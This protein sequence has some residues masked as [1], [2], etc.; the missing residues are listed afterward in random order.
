MRLVEKERR[1]NPES[2]KREN[3]DREDIDR[4]TAVKDQNLT[5]KV[6]GA[7]KTDRSINGHQERASQDLKCTTGGVKGKTLLVKY[8]TRGE[9]LEKT[10][11][12]SSPSE[13]D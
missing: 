11:L 9:K 2:L 10:V 5:S 12:M 6:L 7:E 13:N 3:K 1:L 4:S 8:R